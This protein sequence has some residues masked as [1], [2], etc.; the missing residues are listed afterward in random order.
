M[1][2]GCGANTDFR[3]SPQ[4]LQWRQFDCALSLQ[5]FWFAFWFVDDKVGTGFYSAAG[6]ITA[7]RWWG[8][9]YPGCGSICDDTVVNVAVIVRRG[10]RYFL[11]F[12]RF[13]E[14][15]ELFV[16]GVSILSLRPFSESLISVASRL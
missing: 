12:D 15:G 13:S 5:L 14:T 6:A 3:S 8:R 7:E 2:A 11:G 10:Q 9:R 16:F 1:L 4:E